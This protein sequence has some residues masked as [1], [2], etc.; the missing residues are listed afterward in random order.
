MSK[1][2]LKMT[3]DERDAEAKSLEKGIPIKDT[4]PLSKHS[5]VL[6]GLAKR[7]PG[8]PPKL[9]SEKA[10]RILIS[11]EPKLLIAIEAF[12]SANDL[13]RSKLFA[14]SVQAF[15]ASDSAHRRVLSKGSTGIRAE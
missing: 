15:I 9:A 7:G 10:K 5:Q 8:R 6:W 13:D 14:L 4:R 12:A 11:I 2:F 3:K 1:H